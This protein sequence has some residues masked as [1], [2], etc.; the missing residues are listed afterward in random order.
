LHGG[1]RTAESPRRSRKPPL[2]PRQQATLARGFTV[3]NVYPVLTWSRQEVFGYLAHHGVAPHP[4][5]EWL[6]LSRHEQL[7]PGEGG[8][9]CSCVCCIYA[10]PEHLVLAQQ[11]PAGRAVLD[12]VIQFE[13]ET[14]RTWSQRYSVTAALLPGGAPRSA[15]PGMPAVSPQQMPLGI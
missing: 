10:A 11:Q 3:T 8:P 5:Y 13:R 12:R 15:G 6:G 4:C 2:E 9:R 1:L 14:G 7:G